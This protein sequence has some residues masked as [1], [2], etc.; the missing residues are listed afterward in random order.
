MTFVIMTFVIMGVIG[1]VMRLGLIRLWF[2][3]NCAGRT[4]CYAFHALFAP[5]MMQELGINRLFRSAK[6]L[7]KPQA[8]GILASLQPRVSAAGTQHPQGWGRSLHLWYEGLLAGSNRLGRFWQVRNPE[9]NHCEDR[10]I[11][12]RTIYGNRLREPES[13]LAGKQAQATGRA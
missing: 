2:L 6:Q 8:T 9:S 13:A 10:R 11:I 1:A 4:Q 5:N 7:S 12:G 3:F